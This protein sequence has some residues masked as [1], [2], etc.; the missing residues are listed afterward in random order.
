MS[1][2]S[3]GDSESPSETE[4]C[5]LD[6]TALVNQ[7]VLRLQISMKNTTLMTEQNSLKDLVGVALDQPRVHHLAGGDRG[8][9]VLLQVHRQVLEDQVQPKK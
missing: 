9:E 5:D 3:D 1:V 6:G 7:Q 8:V 4:V 2:N